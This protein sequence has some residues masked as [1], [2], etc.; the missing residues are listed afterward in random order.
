VIQ[1]ANHSVF[2][3]NKH[4]KKFLF[5]F[6]Y[7]A[8]TLFTAE[9][10][11]AQ[12]IEV[13]SLQ[14]EQIKINSLLADT[15]NFP[16]IDRPVSTDRY[17]SIIS[18][19]DNY[20]GWW[21][22]DL[23]AQALYSNQGFNVGLLPIFI[24]QTYNSRIPHGENNG[25]AWYGR[26]SNMEFKGGFFATSR[27]LSVNISPHIIYQENLNFLR[28]R[29]IPRDA[30]GNI[31]Y[32]AEG[33][34]T[35][36][37]APFRFGPD[38]YTTIDPGNSSIRLHYKKLETGISTEP[39][40]WG[41]AVRYPLLFSNNAPGIPHFFLSNHE[42]FSIPYFGDVKAKWIFGYPNDSDY[43]DG[44]GQNETR[45]TTALNVAYSPIF[46]KNLTIGAI[47]VIH[48]YEEGGFSL[49]NALLSLDPTSLSSSFN[50]STQGVQ[51]KNQAASFYAHIQLPGTNAEIYG[52]FFREDHSYDIRDFVN[53]PHHNS[54]YTFGFQ[55]ISF[56][57]GIDFL[58]TNVEITNLTTTQLEQV[59][60]QAYYYTHGRVRQGHTNGGQILGAAIGPGSNSQFLS[61]DAYKG[62]YKFGIF[63]QRLV[64][65]E[66]FHFAQGSRSITP[67]E[68]FGDFFR[69]RVD[70]NFG[71]NFLYGPGPFY[72][73]GRFTWTKAYNYGRFNYG[74]FGGINI[75][76]YERD[77]LINIQFQLGL[78]YIFSR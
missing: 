43:F 7:A 41:S 17:R 58:K 55:K 50:Q 1:Q 71:L 35:A 39:L 15:V 69:H 8:F 66:N 46:W 44:P 57:P 53:Q 26:G 78:T 74:E 12:I 33:I 36:L 37:D 40:W 73:N 51:D 75:T 23:S 2:F 11:T 24:Q 77:D 32:V 64:D 20:T 18:Q 27:Y 21:N 19:S 49:S 52:E 47:R 10:M 60:P 45:F 70:L 9:R 61:I 14:D 48:L 76:N 5:L 54:A 62:D 56:L 38:T 25:A 68:D 63:A 42:P 28:P 29:F 59:R 6:L 67:S 13:G 65:N 3:K 4:T 72:I 16:L 22:R 30:D 31:R 34:G